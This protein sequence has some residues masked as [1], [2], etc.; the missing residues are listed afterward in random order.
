LDSD[1]YQASGLCV[2]SGPRDPA[3]KARVTC[4]YISLPDDPLV[5]PLQIAM[6]DGS[7][8]DSFAL[9]VSRAIRP[10][11]VSAF[12]Q[13]IGTSTRYGN[14]ISDE[15]FTSTHS[16]F[17]VSDVMKPDAS[18]TTLRGSAVIVGAHWRT[19]AADRGDFVDEHSTPV[20]RIVGAEL[21]AN[22]VE[23]I[24]DGRTFGTSPAW[25][26]HGTEIVLSLVAA[27]VF[28]LIAG[29]LGKLAG[30]A[31]L[32]LVLLFIQWSVLHLFGVFFDAFV[33]ILGL[34]LHALY[35]RLFSG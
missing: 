33:P 30:V 25:L 16:T 5:V 28:A 27:V 6:A 4:G 13:R 31:L 2:K 24:L 34:G 18:N 3:I 1:I 32:L 14:Y 20:G 17:S 23:D 11:L 8:L 19:F 10:E 22:F 29:F 35:D 12:L 26:L 9:A 7:Y 21:Q 15:K